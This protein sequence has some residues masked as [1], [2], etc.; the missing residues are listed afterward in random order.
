MNLIDL[1]DQSILEVKSKEPPRDYLGVSCIGKKC[2]RYLQFTYQNHPKDNGGFSPNTYRIFDVGNNIEP[3]IVKWL[4]DAGFEIELGCGF[5]EDGG[6]IKGHA[7]GVITKIP[8]ILRKKAPCL[9]ELKTINSK[10]F[11]FLKKK[12]NV[13]KWNESY[14]TQACTY[15]LGLSSQFPGIECNES[16]FIG[17]CKNDCKL[18]IEWIPPDPKHAET[19]INRARNVFQNI[20]KGILSEKGFNDSEC[21]DCT[22]CSFRSNCW[23][24]T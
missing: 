5:S 3:L 10:G 16:L 22:Y 15:P 6:K 8:K 19:C 7:D 4:Q 12:G 1:L 20:E 21:F 23:D 14:Y 9:L 24:F 17:L 18:Y 2:E 13:K 11:Y